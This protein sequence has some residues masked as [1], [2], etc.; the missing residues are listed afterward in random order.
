MTEAYLGLSSDDPKEALALA[1][2]RSGRPAHL[3]EKDVMVVWALGVLGTSRFDKHLAFKGGTSLSKAYGSIE[4]FSDDIDL[5]YDVREI[6]PDLVAKTESGWPET[7]SQQK[8]W[9]K[10]IRARLDRW[11]E[12]DIAPV[13]ETAIADAKLDGKVELTGGGSLTIAYGALTVGTGYVL[14]RVL[15]E[16]GARATGEPA[17]RKSITYDA[18]PF[19]A[20]IEFPTATPRVMLATRT[21]WEKATAIHIFCRQGRFRGGDR[22]ARHWYDIV[23]LDD[24]GIAGA[25]IADRALAQ[26]VANHKQLFFAEK[27]EAGQAISYSAAVGGGLLLAPRGEARTAL[28]GDYARVVADGLILGEAPAFDALMQRCDDLAARANAVAAFTLP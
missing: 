23:R 22:F 14:P 24:A 16:F 28:A 17:E 18:A 13:F 25:S 2:S 12:T 6:A 26:E 8:A 27:D 19:L 4:R 7:N 15:L 21:F 20:K 9:A 5:T 3:L 1:A 11:I 10:E